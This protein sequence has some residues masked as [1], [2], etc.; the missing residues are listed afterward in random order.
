MQAMFGNAVRL[1]G[2]AR[3]AR[4]RTRQAIQA[5]PTASPGD[6]AVAVIMS[7][8]AAEG[9]INELA[10]AARVLDREPGSPGGA[11]GRPGQPGQASVG[12][13]ASVPAVTEDSQA[14]AKLANLARLLGEV[15]ESRGTVQL[16]YQIAS[17]ALSG[18]TFDPGMNPFQDFDTLVEVRNLLVHFRPRDKFATDHEGFVT[19]NEHP[20]SVR[21]LQ[22]RG[23]A[24][25]PEE[26]SLH[27]WSGTLMTREMADWACS[28][29]LEMILAIVRL[30]PPSNT[31]LFVS[32]FERI[33]AL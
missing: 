26:D 17:L 1:F 31:R 21:A 8:V 15:E 4:D 24:K 30:V 9:F 12:G 6:A 5:Q 16:K 20:R 22:Q 29:A 10:E 14:R 28:T 13:D 32:G 23:L 11:P 18:R 3:E 19:G 33:P 27:S 25:R 2:F 7:A